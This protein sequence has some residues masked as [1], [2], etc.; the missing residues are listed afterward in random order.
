MLAIIASLLLVTSACSST[1]P[2]PAGTSPGTVATTGSN[3]VR[4]ALSDPVILFGPEHAATVA[5]GGYSKTNVKE[6]LYEHARVPLECRLHGGA[7]HA[8][9]AAVNEA[10]FAQPPR[11]R[12]VDVLVDD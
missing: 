8:A 12:G 1:V 7:L 2:A 3:N 5:A 6:Y 11:R 10:H 4:N 9:A